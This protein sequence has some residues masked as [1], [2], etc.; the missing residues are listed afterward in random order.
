MGFQEKSH[1]KHKGSVRFLPP[2]PSM[3]VHTINLLRRSLA[4][5]LG[6]RSDEKSDRSV[7]IEDPKVTKKFESDRT[8]FAD[9]FFRSD[10]STV[11]GPKWTK[12]D[13]F[14]PKWTK[15]D[16]FG[17]FWSCE[18]QNPVRNEVILT[19]IVVLTI[20]DHFGP[21]HFPTVPRPRPT[22]CGTL[23]PISGFIVSTLLMGESACQ[24]QSGAFTSTA[25]TNRL[26]IKRSRSTS[27]WKCSDHHFDAG[28]HP[29]GKHK[30]PPCQFYYC[31]IFVEELIDM[32]H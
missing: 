4:K 21:V 24:M 30:D 29:S 3:N 6:K 8:H 13:L 5:E 25:E 31:L 15:M 19:K 17:P 23:I 1:D 10:Q 22:F 2:P 32:T 7:Q 14:R 27:V 16:H 26:L 18:Y 12:I 11:G 20:L 9:L 28:T